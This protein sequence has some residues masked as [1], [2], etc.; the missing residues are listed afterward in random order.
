MEKNHMQTV[1]II[2]FPDC[3]MVSSGFGS[4]GEPD[5]ALF[6]EMVWETNDLS[7]FVQL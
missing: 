4:F 2:Y 6:Q 7:R 3:K 5:F 1:R